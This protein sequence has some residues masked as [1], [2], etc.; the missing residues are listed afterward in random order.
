MVKQVINVGSS[1]N[2]GTGDTLRQGAQKINENFT[3]LYGAVSYTLPLAS[4]SVRGGVVIDG[5]TVKMT[6][7]I[8]SAVGQPQLV[9]HN[10]TVT[11][12]SD[13]VLTAA[14]GGVVSPGFVTIGSSS[15]FQTTEDTGLNIRSSVDNKP[16]YIYG[17]GTDGTGVT[18][19]EIDVLLN[20]VDIYTAYG[21][22]EQSKWSF[23]NVEGNPLFETPNL[24]V[25]TI[26]WEDQIISKN[27]AH[28]LKLGSTDFKSYISVFGADSTSID[29]YDHFTDAHRIMLV[30]N[31]DNT[32]AAEGRITLVASNIS[33]FSRASI[34]IGKTG[35]Q[36]HFAYIGETP[37]SIKT[38]IEL[39]GGTAHYGDVYLGYDSHFVLG[40]TG[41]IFRDGSNLTSA[42]NGTEILLNGD[43]VALQDNI[44]S[45][46]GSIES[47]TNQVQSLNNQAQSLSSQ[48]AY[49]G[50]QPDFFGPGQPNSQKFA[51]IGQL[52]GQLNQVESEISAIESS[53]S[54]WAVQMDLMQESLNNPQLGFYYN[55]TTQQLLIDNGAHSTVKF[56]NGI[57]FG[58]DSKQ[59]TAFVPSEYINLADLKTL[60]AACDNFDDFKTLIAGYIIITVGT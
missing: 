37:I 32:S 39:T 50:S 10:Y 40:Q 38:N 42:N 19:S 35:S 57:V 46:T 45:L 9:N 43:M 15:I 52:S 56:P 25:G 55:A 2:D 1:T 4:T 26:L 6:D 17:Y 8:L 31:T 33:S 11:L 22:N 58:N 30:S 16:I 28:T 44:D 13:G 34:D 14:A 21:T 41:I 54:T 27:T 59:T 7:G 3:E 12:D 47:A 18:S 23:R 51:M 24:L 48:L 36:N 5:T 60:V 29:Q 53:L 20:R 49:W